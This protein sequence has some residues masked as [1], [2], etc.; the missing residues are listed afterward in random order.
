[1]QSV[2]SACDL[3]TN[4]LA[5]NYVVQ[6]DAA[7][8][9]AGQ[10]LAG[11]ASSLGSAA[12]P[13]NN[14]DNDDNGTPLPEVWPLDPHI[15][16]ESSPGRFHAYFLCSGVELGEFKRLQEEIAARFG[17]DPS[18]NDLPRVMRLPGFIHRKCVPFRSRIVRECPAQPYMRDQLAAAFGLRVNEL[19]PFQWTPT[20]R[21]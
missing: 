11:L 13:D 16:L 20:V 17:S 4:L 14:V 12:D 8:F 10:P 15:V 5:G 6:V 21:A 2:R 18:V 19:S 7:N 3:F 9:G 1:M